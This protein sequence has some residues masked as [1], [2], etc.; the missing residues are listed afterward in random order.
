MRLYRLLF[1][2]ADLFRGLQGLHGALG[3]AQILPCLR[4]GN[5]RAQQISRVIS[6]D[7]R[8]TFVLMESAPK[9]AYA[10]IGIEQIP[11]G[12]FAKRDDKLRFDQIDLPREVW[13][14]TLRF[15]VGRLAITRWTAFYDV[16]YKDILTS[17][18]TNGGQHVIQQLAC[19]PYEGF[20]KGV[21]LRTGSLAHA[22]PVRIRIP[23][24]KHGART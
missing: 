17:L 16:G 10:C 19:L 12:G 3:E 14:A 4:F 9:A 1:P 15:V 20:T 21:L 8:N 24:A 13:L 7:H 5:Q 23:H 18:Q 11:G 6:D 2:N 22:K